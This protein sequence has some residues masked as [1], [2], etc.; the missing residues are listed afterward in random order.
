[1][2]SLLIEPER[3]CVVLAFGTRGKDLPLTF[4]QAETVAR[5]LRDK[6]AVCKA[7]VD[8][9][10]ARR[11]ATEHRGIGVEGKMDGTLQDG[12]IWLRFPETVKTEKVPFEAAIQLA[13][14][15]EATLRQLCYKVLW[16]RGY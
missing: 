11:L 13:D 5:V 16:K 1:M 8:A 15:I 10:G 4:E 7:W 3:D 6:A 9:G 14:A 12:R 2:M